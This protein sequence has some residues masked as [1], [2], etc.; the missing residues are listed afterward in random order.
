[1]VVLSLYILHEVCEAEEVVYSQ[2]S[3]DFVQIADRLPLVI[4]V[5]SV[6]D[7]EHHVSLVEVHHEHEL[8][9][10]VDVDM[11]NDNCHDESPREVKDK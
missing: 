2:Q 7:C 11:H 5:D 8:G 6:I 9:P 1:M 10:R 3:D 4:G